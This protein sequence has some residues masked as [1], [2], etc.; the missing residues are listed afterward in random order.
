MLLSWSW[1]V[2]E[3]DEDLILR[4]KTTKGVAEQRVKHDAE[5]VEVS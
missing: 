4:C 5:K 1:V 2:V 3:V